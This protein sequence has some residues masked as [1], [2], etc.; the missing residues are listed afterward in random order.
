MAQRSTFQYKF[1]LHAQ[2]S[3][4]RSTYTQTTTLR[5]AGPETDAGA[6]LCA[7]S[8]SSGVP[9]TMPRI[10]DIPGRL[11]PPRS[12]HESWLRRLV[13][14][15]CQLDN[16]RSVGPCSNWF[17]RSNAAFAYVDFQVASPSAL[18][19]GTWRSW[20]RKSECL[21]SCFSRQARVAC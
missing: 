11:I 1:S 7:T 20:S 9:T 16:E 15:L 14:S 10:P 13:A 21:Y 12:D 2:P 5:R 6:A 19:A 18:G 3:R 8:T 4:L 17:G